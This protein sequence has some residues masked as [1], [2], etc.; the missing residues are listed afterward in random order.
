[1]QA[2]V[3]G[4][5]KVEGHLLA[6]MCNAAA[7][8]VEV[9]DV[10]DA[11]VAMEYMV[12]GW[13]KYTNR[14]T[15]DSQAGCISYQQGDNNCVVFS[16]SGGPRVQFVRVSGLPPSFIDVRQAQKVC[17]DAREIKLDQST[18]V[19]PLTAPTI[20]PPGSRKIRTPALC[21]ARCHP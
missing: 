9:H 12:S 8:A 11:A 6:R 15:V 19:Q 20:S 18:N 4:G 2:Q 7:A 10:V 13:T 16:L 5:D 3:G 14:I 21:C 17:Q 1:M